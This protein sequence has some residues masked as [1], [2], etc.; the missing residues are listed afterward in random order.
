MKTDRCEKIIRPALLSGI[1]L[2]ASL[3]VGCGQARRPGAS[4]A[5]AVIDLVAQLPGASAEEV[6]RQVTI[7][8][9][10]TMAG[11]PRLESIQSVSRF[12]LS[13]IRLGFT[14]ATYE[15]ARQEVINRLQVIAVP[16]PA[17]VTPLLSPIAE[18]NELLRYILRSPKDRSGKNLYTLSDLGALQDWALER[19]FRRLPGV[20]DVSSAGGIVKR[21]EIHADPERLRRYG[22]TLA[23]LQTAL[24]ESNASV[25]GDYVEQGQVAL[26]VRGIGLF[27]GG[28]DPVQKALR[29][30]SASEAAAMLRS[31]EARRIREIRSLVI[32]S[33]DNKPIRVED[34]V[35]GGR[36]RPGSD[37]PQGVVVG[38][39]QRRGKVLFSAAGGPED[40]EV[41][42]G[43]VL[44]RPGEDP[45]EILPHVE[46]RLQ[47]LRD[48]P[49]HLLPEVR[50]EPYWKRAT[51]AEA[52]TDE[53]RHLWAHAV[54]PFSTSLERVSEVTRQARKIVLEFP[55]A[56]AV[57][58]QIGGCEDGTDV[59]GFETVEAAILLRPLKDWPNPPGS[60]H[61]RTRQELMTA[62]E[63]E[64]RRK[65]PGVVL[66]V[67]N[68][69]RDHFAAA[70]EGS[71]GEHV[72]K[73][74]GPDLEV[75]ERLAERAKKELLRI[76]GIA[77]VQVG[78]VMGEQRLE[79][80]VDPEKCKKWG[81]SVADVNNI[82]AAAIGGQ[83][84]TQM[85]EG[86]K[87]YD[88]AIRW[89][90]HRRQSEEAIL[91]IP[92]DV[93]N[94]KVVPGEVAKPGTLAP[95]PGGVAKPGSP[96]PAPIVAAAPRIRLRDLVTP[97]GDDGQPDPRGKFLRA[98]AAV[99]YREQGK[100]LICVRF[101][102]RGGDPETTLAE[103]QK[104]LAFL[105]EAPYRAVWSSRP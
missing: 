54:F 11:A 25:G 69:S 62:L 15:Q 88:I 68:D 30:K 3:L 2:I 85:I 27:G 73:I 47:E 6:E 24:S 101:R 46:K 14:R 51:T 102:V 70:F 79:F 8:L 66:D 9:E 42:S 96:A 95:A 35:E 86:E 92:V 10:V 67:S 59:V 90:K 76:D 82:L 19:E 1:I 22:I 20:V 74:I 56:R 26:T 64:L 50:L 57:V 83:R 36:A 93:V 65:L 37:E 84:S 28:A 43:V 72:L 21:Y 103:A 61:R 89:P 100:R 98:G 52:R 53:A 4:P 71:S 80:R 38:H 75:L 99:I 87:T 63:K 39:P 44:L 45:A 91:D 97:L 12:G 58:A 94:N 13:Q 23:Q 49:G 105:F 81:V 7:P 31:E 60:D 104:Q 77:D 33:V 32:A 34:I 48:V 18:G 55:E 17:G 41:V 78:H 40:E 5:P 29:L 16:L